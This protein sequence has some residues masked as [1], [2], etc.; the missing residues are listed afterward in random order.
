MAHG[1]S[2]VNDSG[3]LMISDATYNLSFAGKATYT[4]QQNFWNAV[5][6]YSANNAQLNSPVGELYYYTMNT[7]GDDAIFLVYAPWPAFAS[8]LTAVKSGSSYTITV[9]AQ[10]TGGLGAI[11][12]S[13]IPQ[14]YCF[15]K[16]SSGASS[17]YGIELYDGSGRV[18]FSTQSNPLLIKAVYNAIYRASDIQVITAVNGVPYL[19]N[20]PSNTTYITSTAPLN[21]VPSISKP[22][23][24]FPSHES[25]ARFNGQLFY[26]F[27]EIGARFDN[28]S[29]SLQSSWF[30]TYRTVANSGTTYNR[31]SRSAYAFVADGA[32]YD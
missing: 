2:A 7:G 22:L 31:P 25:A 8:V 9:A 19:G 11:P 18:A 15:K 21:S 4:G 3:Y 24:Y 10:P 5:V 30:M 13:L 26:G 28:S 32:D 17:G 29:K 27:W 20:G 12:A 14:V 1:F 23:I 6:Y 16:I